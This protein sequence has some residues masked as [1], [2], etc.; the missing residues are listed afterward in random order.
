MD[1]CIRVRI[2]N[3]QLQ[4]ELVHSPVTFMRPVNLPCL[5]AGEV[6]STGSNGSK[7]Y[8]PFGVL[9]ARLFVENMRR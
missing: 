4:K 6:W 1:L 2:K 7:V 8:T 5:K 9:T 3:E